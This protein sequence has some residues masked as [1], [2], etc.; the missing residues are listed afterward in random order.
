VTAL[1]RIA[2]EEDRSL[3]MQINRAQREWLEARGTEPQAKS[4]SGR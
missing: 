4:P 1:K 3:N 2:A